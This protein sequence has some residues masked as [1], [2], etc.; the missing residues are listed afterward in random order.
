VNSERRIGELRLKDRALGT[1]GS[2]TQFFMHEGRR[3]GHLID[4]RSGQPAEGVFSVSVMAPTAAE[5]DALATA[6]YVMGPEA[7]RDYCAAHPQIG[8]VM[9]CPDES[10]GRLRV[11]AFGLDQSDW[12]V[13]EPS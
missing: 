7:T 4:P 6:F 10:E 9:L 2:G 1:S 3:Y 11:H 12:T 13:C 8:C 5:A